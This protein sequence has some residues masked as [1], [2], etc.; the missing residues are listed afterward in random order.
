MAIVTSGLIALPAFG[1]DAGP[2]GVP[3]YDFSNRTESVR[4]PDGSPWALYRDVLVEET[5]AGG[6]DAVVRSPQHWNKTPLHDGTTLPAQG[7]HTFHARVKL[8][9]DWLGPKRVLAV[10]FPYQFHA[11]K[12]VVRNRGPSG[13]QWEAF[14]GRPSCDSASEIPLHRPTRLAFFADGEVDIFLQISNHHAMRGGL[15]RGL[16]VGP[17]D[18]IIR[19]RSVLEH[20]DLFILGVLVVMAIYHL[21]QWLLFRA[22][23][24]AMFFSALCF[25]MAVRATV[26]GNYLESAVPPLIGFATS[27]RLVY[28]TID[29]AVF[30]T[31]AFLDASLPNTLPRWL[32]RS[33]GI[34][35]GT[36][37]LLV[38]VL[39]VT[40]FGPL[41]FLSEAL[42]LIGSVVVFW[43]CAAAMIRQRT[44]H[45]T[46]FFLSFGLLA[47]TAV[48]DLLSDQLRWTQVFA[49]P[50]GTMG[51]VLI[52]A[53]AI[54]LQN[55]KAREHAETLT[56]ELSERNER[57]MKLDALKNEFL[58]TTSHELRTPLNGII[59]LSETL[60]QRSSV[61]TDR[62]ATDHLL[63][64]GEAGRRLATLINDI[65]DYSKL[66]TRTITLDLCPVDLRRSIEQVMLLSRTLPGTK[67][68]DLREAVSLD[69]P[70][71]QADENRLRQVLQNI[72]GNAIKFTERGFV[73]VSANV[74]GAFVEVRVR[75]SGIGISPD[76]FKYI[77]ESFEQLETG[78]TRQAQG[79]GLGLAITRQL[80]ELQG[81]TIQ[82]YSAPNLGSTFAFT[83]P[84]AAD[85][86]GVA[87]RIAP[88]TREAPAL[89]ELPPVP[90]V[91]SRFQPSTLGLK[92]ILAVDDDAAN[93]LV[94]RAQLDPKEFAVTPVR[95][96][97]DTVRI[98]RD[99]G[100]FDA[101][102]L[103]IMMPKISGLEVARDLCRLGPIGSCPILFLSARTGLEDFASA[104]AAGGSDFLTK[105]VVRSELLTRLRYHLS[106]AASLRQLERP[107][108]VSLES[109]LSSNEGPVVLVATRIAAST[110]SPAV[111]AERVEAIRAA[112][113]VPFL[114]S[115]NVILAFT[116][117][118]D[119]AQIAA[120]HAAIQAFSDPRARVVTAAGK[121]TF[122]PLAAAPLSAPMLQGSPIDEVLHALYTDKL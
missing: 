10:A 82:V 69:V 106:V 59:G 86:R 83:I 1:A 77:F 2:L 104:F 91:E 61:R 103:D 76:K 53:F 6:V 108:E 120:L 99:E 23:R 29:G 24:Q 60:L 107:L 31:V 66:R 54:A 18:E 8:P 111:I 92:R 45:S 47:V 118:T 7:C 119:D 96:A 121:V 55:A 65:L 80:V 43:C 58:A 70:L 114:L 85:A 27:Q 19:Q 115:G 52:Q 13:G 48:W 12:L 40:T 22:Q 50:Y 109:F 113:A 78:P 67:P 15:V 4:F 101:V 73:E 74:K 37:S 32:L 34:A 68:I 110:P 64:I 79:T 116:R 90:P 26:F 3:V 49:A 75:D 93:L 112:N 81:G 21:A 117:T 25:V 5:P 44:M 30:F 56:A 11:A 72:V 88:R 89:A 122:A 28:L 97:R 71:V 63:A 94:L 35:C 39:D 87:H 36:I 62:E 95:D 105:P 9:S 42:A 20:G 16:S 100:P 17:L 98:F 84:I 57:I 46:L 33:L 41:I 102:L 14:S 38:L 51:F